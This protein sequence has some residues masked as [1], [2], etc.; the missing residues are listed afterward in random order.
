MSLSRSLG[1]DRILCR[2][3]CRGRGPCQGWTPCRRWS[4][5][6]SPALIWC[7]DVTRGVRCRLARISGLALRPG[8]SPAATWSCGV[9][10]AVPRSHCRTTR[11]GGGGPR[12]V[13]RLLA[14]SL[15]LL[16]P[17][18]PTQVAPLLLVS[19]SSAARRQVPS[20]AGVR[21]HG[22]MTSG[23][24]RHL[25]RLPSPGQGATSPSGPVAGVNSRRVRSGPGT[26]RPG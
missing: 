21:S 7:Y 24:P 16:R 15:L 11:A 9:T 1:M 19:S 13:P 4:A 2:G 12:S 26:S 20:S 5:C 6:P 18:G 17:R 22:L 14:S 10:R 3:P 25:P 8:P 23:V